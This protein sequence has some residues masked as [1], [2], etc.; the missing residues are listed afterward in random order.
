[1]RELAASDLRPISNIQK[2]SHD[3]RNT[4]TLDDVL[5]CLLASYA[6]MRVQITTL[7]AIV[8]CELD[9]G[10]REPPS[11]VHPCDSRRRR[12]VLRF[13]VHQ[14]GDGNVVDLCRG[15]QLVA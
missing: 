13:A 1:M 8:R 5:D 14:L 9:G 6:E 11:P 15:W 7:F 12:C 4:V 10:D 3:D 2:Q